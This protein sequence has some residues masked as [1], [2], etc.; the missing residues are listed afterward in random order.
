MAIAILVL[1]IALRHEKQYVNF[2]YEEWEKGDKH[3]EEHLEKNNIRKPFPMGR[4]LKDGMY[5]IRP[6]KYER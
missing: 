3:M 2:I 6:R 5:P 1:F 4:T